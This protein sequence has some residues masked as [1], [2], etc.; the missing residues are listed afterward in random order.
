MVSTY[1]GRGIDITDEV[2]GY[3][4]RR[5]E[6]L[7]RLLGRQK[8]EPLLRCDLELHSGEASAPYMVRAT[9]DVAGYVLH[10]ES[11]G[12]SLH[13]AIDMAAK[14]LVHEAEKI[15]GRRLNI[16]RYASK[17]KDFLRGLRG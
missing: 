15:K 16:R 17:A 14:T 10:A 2:R 4:E 11:K 6:H 1:T 12:T 13:E 3:A 8:V 5:F 7:A 9:I